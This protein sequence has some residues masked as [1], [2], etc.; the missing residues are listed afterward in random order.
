[1]NIPKWIQPFFIIAGLCDA[2]LGIAFLIVPVQFFNATKI[3]PPNEMGYIQVLA[4]MLVA[5]ALMYFNIAK[6]PKVNRNLIFY[7]ILFK[8]SF[9]LVVFTHWIAGNISYLWVLFAFFD[10]GFITVFLAAAK[11]LK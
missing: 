10:I 11:A 7:G 4:L 9:C 6:E 5:F 2:I 1:M 8:L 3:K